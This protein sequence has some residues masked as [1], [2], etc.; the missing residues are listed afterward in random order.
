MFL[1]RVRN[2]DLFLGVVLVFLIVFLCF[3]QA[4]FWQ[5]AEQQK[6]SG[7]APGARFR[8]GGLADVAFAGRLQHGLHLVQLGLVVLHVLDERASGVVGAED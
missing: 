4:S 5:S 2:S 8:C 3:F 7:F 1:W 6:K